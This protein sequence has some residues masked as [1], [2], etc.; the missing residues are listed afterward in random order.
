[1]SMELSPEQQQRIHQRA[2]Q[3]VER[4]TRKYNIRER[5]ESQTFINEFFRIFNIDRLDSNIYFERS[6]ANGENNR[7]IDVLWPRVILIENKSSGENLDR[8]FDQQ[9]RE[10]FYMLR[11]KDRPECILINNF[12]MF[13]LYTTENEHLIE[14]ECFHIKKLPDKIHL[15][16]Y[17]FKHSPAIIKQPV[18]REI[19]KSTH[20]TKYSIL[21]LAVVSSVFLMIGYI[22]SDGQPRAFLE[23]V[24][25]GSTREESTR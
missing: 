18:E 17:F 20:K 14:S 12:H 16:Y 10:Y 3:F 2:K 4:W 8:A 21:K 15:F 11:K 19:K 6:L 23:S 7:R 5:E 24:I 1:M 25:G 22:I 9:A 13:K